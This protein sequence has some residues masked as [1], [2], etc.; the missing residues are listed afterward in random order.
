MPIEARQRITPLIVR[1]PCLGEPPGDGGVHGN[2]SRRLCSRTR[3]QEPREND[4]SQQHERVQLGV[5]V[6]IVERTQHPIKGRRALGLGIALGL[7]LAGCSG[8]PTLDAHPRFDSARAEAFLDTLERRTFDYFW[9]LTPAANG[10]TPDR[11]PSASPAS[12]AAVGFALTAYPIGVERGYIQRDQA[13]ERTL[14]TLRFFWN[15]PQNFGRRGRDRLPRLLLSLPRHAGRHP[16]QDNR[17]T[18]I[19]TALLLAG[20][21]FCQ[22]YFDGRDPVEQRSV[23]SPTR[24]TPGLTGAGPWPGHRRCPWGWT[25]KRIHRCRLDRLQRG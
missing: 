1:R 5:K 9:D 13:A 11:A 6:G 25:R 15:A 3:G 8:S 22:S 20:A 24:C 12:I 21:L 18:T 10:L 19:D 4:C 16:L 7:A 23:R 2:G 17:V 14:T